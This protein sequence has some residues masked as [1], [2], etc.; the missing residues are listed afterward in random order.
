MVKKLSFLLLLV[1]NLTLS[2]DYIAILD[3]NGATQTLLYK[4]DKHAKLITQDGSSKS[5][6]YLIGTKSYI[7]SEE[8]GQ[9]TVMDMDEM[10]Q[11]TKA[12]GGETTTTAQQKMSDFQIV[13]TNKHENVAGIKGTI[14]YLVDPQTKKRYKVVV[15]NNPNVKKSFHV[16]NIFLS[17]F[18]DNADKYNMFELEN[19]YVVIKAEGMELKK[20]KKKSLPEKTYQLPKDAVK[21]N[22]FGFTSLLGNE[23]KNK[24]TQKQ[25]SQ[26]K[27]SLLN[28]CYNEVCCGS[29]AGPSK[30]LV[31]MLAKRAGGYRLQGS[32]VCDLLGISSVFG[33][34]NIEGALYKKGDDAI[35]VSLSMNSNEPSTVLAA[36][37][38]TNTLQAKGYKRG[39]IDGYTYHYAML[40][41]IKQQEIDIII[42]SKTILKITRLATHSEINLISWAKRAINLD[43]YTPPQQLRQKKSISSKTTND[44]EQK[45]L[46]DEE[47]NKAVNMLKTLF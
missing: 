10:R 2:A 46:S 29:T 32:G 47:I 9:K 21:A 42:D 28:K 30:V 18:T 41:P 11:M 17:S 20:F 31:K 8:D 3:L 13:K 5:S 7:V 19:G 45:D 37:N 23:K 15:T 16:M 40:L 26:K 22:M 25:E 39:A 1:T 38:G 44:T 27:Q 34:E 35:E 14:W 4:D 6:F 43:A 24:K 12:F 33:F 36:K